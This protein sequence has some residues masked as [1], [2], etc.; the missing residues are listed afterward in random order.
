LVADTQY[1]ISLIPSLHLCLA[2]WLLPRWRAHL[3]REAPGVEPRCSLFPSPLLRLF[4]ESTYGRLSWT[5]LFSFLSPI[6]LSIVGHRS[7]TPRLRESQASPH[8]SQATQSKP[9]LPPAQPQPALRP[10]TRFDQSGPADMPARSR[11]H[12]IYVPA[13]LQRRDREPELTSPHISDEHSPTRG[14]VEPREETLPSWRVP[15]MDPAAG[16]PDRSTPGSSSAP[17]TPTEQ[18][19]TYP[20]HSNPPVL[21][22][23]F[24]MCLSRCLL[25]L[26]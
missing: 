9:S 1:V 3:S 22:T 11:N 20:K 21:H 17:P 16:I 25:Y 7:P 14:R 19:R 4:L 24:V 12:D 5:R 10:N 8:V 2:L 26:V 15:P 18:S 23:D 13:D 6:P